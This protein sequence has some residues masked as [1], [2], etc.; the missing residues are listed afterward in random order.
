MIIRPRLYQFFPYISLLIFLA[1]LIVR[2]FIVNSKSAD[3]AGIEQNVVYSTQM[4]MD[5]GDLYQSPGNAPFSI[6]QYTPLYYYICGYTAKIIGYGPDDVQVLYRIGRSWNILFNFLTALLVFN[7]GRS[8]LK[9]SV[10]KSYFLF[11]L[12]FALLFTHN[13]AV[14]SD[15]LTDMLGMASI[16]FFLRYYRPQEETNSTFLLILTVLLTALAVFSKQ[17]GIQLIIIFMGISVLLADWKTLIKLILVT[18]L[19]YGGFILLFSHLYSSFL[20]NV[21][22]GIANGISLPNFFRVLTHNLVISAVWPLIIISVI[23]LFKDKAICKGSKTNRILSICT[24]G[25]LVF[26]TATALKMGSTA[27]YFTLFINLALL[28]V[29]NRLQHTVIPAPSNWFYKNIRQLFYCFLLLIIV[30]CGLYD[31]KAIYNNSYEPYLVKQR[32]A[33]SQVVDFIKKDHQSN[34]PFYLFSNLSTDSSLPS[35]QVINNVFFKN[36]LLPQMDILQYSTGPSKVVGYK[37]L[38]NMLSS[39]KVEYIIESEP[40]LSFVLLDHLEDIKKNKFR[41]IKQID[42]YLIYKLLPNK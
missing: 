1:F 37:N 22:G 3:I 20:L 8:I 2:I 23:I 19:I 38:E 25:S 42:G 24:L 35:R 29:M 36:S 39:G 21:V 5:K 26:A 7:I 33:A 14:R 11:A 4:L 31:I 6:T 34:S 28:M 17:S 9:L 40:K 41:L 16:Y 32:E 15:S 10:N 30:L 13:F 27:Q 18:I 12:S